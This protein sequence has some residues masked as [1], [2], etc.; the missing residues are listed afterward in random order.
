MNT[1]NSISDKTILVHN[2]K[3]SFLGP[4]SEAINEFVKCSNEE[5]LNSTYLTDIT[6]ETKEFVLNEAIV[7]QKDQKGFSFINTVPIKVKLDYE[8]KKQVIG[9]RIG[10]DLMDRQTGTI[11]FRSYQDDLSNNIN[12]ISP[13]RYNSSVDLPIDFLKEGSY[14]ICILVGIHNQK[15]ISKDDLKFDLN[16]I[17]AGGVNSE[18]A[19]NRPG[20]ISPRLEWVNKSTAI[21]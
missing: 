9:F 5:S 11:L 7:S 15:W 8:I 18:Y 3:K 16:I 2:G 4:S 20:F 21:V 19:D 12:Y 1:I 10:F 13:G 6:L 14:A 17:G